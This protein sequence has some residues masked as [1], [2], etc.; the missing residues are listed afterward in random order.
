MDLDV[1]HVELHESLNLEGKSCVELVNVK[2]VR[3]FCLIFFTR[4]KFAKVYSVI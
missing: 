1:V 3:G 4:R 2:D